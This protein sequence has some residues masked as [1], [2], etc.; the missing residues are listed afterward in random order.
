VVGRPTGTT[1]TGT[2]GRE[3]GFLFAVRSVDAA[4]NV[5]GNSVVVP[6]SLLDTTPP[7]AS[8]TASARLESATQVTLR[9]SAAS[10]D[11]GVV[12]YRITRD[13]E[14]L[15]TVN[16]RTTTDIRVPAGPHTYGVSAIDAAG[17]ASTVTTATVVAPPAAPS[18]LTG[19]YF[20]TATFTSERTVRTD[21]TVDFG[22]GTGRPT[23]TVAPD[24]FSVRWTGRV[25]PAADG[26]WTFSASSDDAV[27][28]WVDGRLV[29]DDWTPHRL[30]EASGSIPLT[31]DRTYDLRIDYVERSGSATVR[32]LW[33][34]PGVAEQIVP[35]GRLLAR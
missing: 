15:R 22:W 23:S 12:G 6:V 25:L 26:T 10:D 24:T 34:G 35:G 32:L 13:G 2:V 31:A 4:G 20:D 1:W 30:R 19:S 27:R 28:V 5:S 14:V 7:T 8:A 16:G 29:V 17:N 21:R 18:G 33:S 9:W 3:T 11:V